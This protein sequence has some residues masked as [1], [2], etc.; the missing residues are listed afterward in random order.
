MVVHGGENRHEAY[1][2]EKVEWPVSV[3]N[4]IHKYGFFTLGEKPGKETLSPGRTK[5]GTCPQ[6]REGE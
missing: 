6:V 2:V 4:N 5:K 1:S 3:R